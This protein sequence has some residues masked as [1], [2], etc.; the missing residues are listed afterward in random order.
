MHFSPCSRGRLTERDLGR[1]PGDT[2]FDRLGRAV[3]G[4]GSLPRKELYEAWAV[5]RRVRR[6]FRGGRVVD[7]GGG[8]GLLAHIMLLLDDSSADALV[9]DIAAP[10]SAAKVQAAIEAAW[11]RLAGRISRAPGRL[12]E[13]EIAAS[14]VVVSSH[15][16]G[17][18]TDRVLER[19]VSGRARVGVLPCCHDLDTGNQ[20]GLGGW[21]DGPLA[22]DI[23]RATRLREHGYRVWT[24]TISSD[25]TPKN[26]LLLGAPAADR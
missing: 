16:C 1:F 18:L 23:V 9:V 25:I 8:H 19:A 14:D 15:A 3:C 21:I 24:Q 26:R 4:A 11:P 22:V 7:L 20:G 5:A 13:V 2:L 6:L 17:S 12:E 10:P